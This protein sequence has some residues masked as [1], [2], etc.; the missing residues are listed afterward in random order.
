[1]QRES[2]AGTLIL[3]VHPAA[4]LII[5]AA[6]FT[7][8]WTSS[9]ILEA[10][11]ATTRFGAD[12]WFYTEIAKGNALARIGESQLL[13]RVFRFHPVT[14]ILGATWMK[15][16]GW[17][18]LWI[19]PQAILRA[20]FAFAGAIGVWAAMS[21][22]AAVMP[23]R[24]VAF[25]G[26]IYAVSLGTWYF[27][28]IEESKIVSASLVAAYIAIYL[29]LRT[30]WTTAR[31]IALTI[32]LL[33]AC[34]NE[35]VAGFLILVPAV[36]TLMKH[37]FN[38]RAGRWVAAH[39]LSGPLALAILEWVARGR[40]GAA[41]ALPE[42]ANHLSMLFWYIAQNDY[43]FASAYAFLMR[44]FF[45]NIAAPE[46]RIHFVNLPKRYGGDFLPDPAVYFSSPAPAAAI[47][48]FAVLLVV[49]F[50]SRF[51]PSISRGMAAIML[52]LAAYALARCLF[53]FIF[54]PAECML[55]SPSVTLAHLLLIAIPFSASNFP[56]RRVLLALFAT[57]LFL[58]NG[59]FMIATQQ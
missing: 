1:M 2:P 34:L 24:H 46:P 30:E 32:V 51:R 57:A 43:S 20:L 15:L 40:S 44:W 41:N 49:I 55:Y 48:L 5:V 29:H 22:F 58:A 33:L 27:A 18:D 42:N 52:A 56:R 39:A 19:T 23:R 16:F 37:G 14:L 53:F 6:A 11:R 38:I 7:L 35:I 12:T 47:I 17:L 21:A 45:F 13:D 4:L 50:L 31:A 8:Y 59:A 9:F 10:N 26:V 25:W 36:D 3:P 54:L 28:S